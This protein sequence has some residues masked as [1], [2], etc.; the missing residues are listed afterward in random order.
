MKPCGG[1]YAGMLVS[2]PCP[3]CSHAVLTHRVTDHVCSVC[4]AVE[5]I[6]AETTVPRA[7]LKGSRVDMPH[8]PD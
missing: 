2:Q 3:V 5:W 1:L 4:E 8:M 6:K 7:V